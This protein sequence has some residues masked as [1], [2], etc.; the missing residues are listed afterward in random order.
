MAFK[1]SFLKDFL[2]DFC[3]LCPGIMFRL[4]FK[5]KINVIIANVIIFINYIF[6]ISIIIPFIC[7][8]KCF[9]PIAFFN[10]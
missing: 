6:I 2:V 9:A 5:I 8:E 1:L 3:F 10:L 7:F 4:D